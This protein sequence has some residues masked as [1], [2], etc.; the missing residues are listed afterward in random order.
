MLR[1][2]KALL[3]IYISFGKKPCLTF[4]AKS[5]KSPRFGSI[6]HFDQNWCFIDISALY[7]ALHLIWSICNPH[8]FPFHFVFWN[9]LSI[10]LYLSSHLPSSIS[11][12]VNLDYLKYDGSFWVF[13]YKVYSTTI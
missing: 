7:Y 11:H 8:L 1:S 5:I 4:F 2:Y 10:F 3:Q 6:F 9:D 12:N 13:F